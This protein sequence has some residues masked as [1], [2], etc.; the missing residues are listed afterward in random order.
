MPYFS[1]FPYVPYK[2]GTQESFTLHQNLTAYATLVDQVRDNNSFY[3]QYTILDGDRP[4]T[5][6]QKL[7]GSTKHYWTFFLM[8]DKLRL[9]GW[10]LRN[11]EVY[12]LAQEERD[13]TVLTSRE[14]LTGIFKV[15]STVSGVT[16]GAS[17]T[18]IKR[19]LELGQLFVEG[20]QPFVA[21]ENI[22]VTE[23]SVINTVS[24]V[25]SV[26]EYE[27][28]WN[29]VNGDEEIV[30]INPYE[31]PGAEFAAKSYYDRYVDEN[32]RLKDIIVIKPDAIDS[33]YEQFQNAMRE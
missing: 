1:N 21:G 24:I 18:I 20:D 19:R 33:V 28:V 13:N 22:Q 16:S 29:Y 14:D 9:N 15:G 32:D 5:L 17:G 7:Y 26:I 10:P 8:N 31:E 11:Q 23:N 4:D 25:G 30:D 3:Q 27:A 12:K 6:S 2:F